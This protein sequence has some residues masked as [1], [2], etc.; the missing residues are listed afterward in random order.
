M[1]TSVSVE[2]VVDLVSQRCDD[3]EPL[4]AEEQ[5]LRR[6][7][8]RRAQGGDGGWVALAS[9]ATAVATTVVANA[10]QATVVRCLVGIAAI[11]L[12]ARFVWLEGCRRKE[13]EHWIVKLLLALAKDLEPKPTDRAFLLHGA[14]ATVSLVTGQ[15]SP[16]AVWYGEVLAIGVAPLIVMWISSP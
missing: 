12:A 5:R 8:L 6:E 11:V 15:R 4:S 2:E 3:V 1:K 16:S 10:G 13:I 14:L 7:I 9:L